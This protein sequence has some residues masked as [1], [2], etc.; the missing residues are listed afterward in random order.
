ME[1]NKIPIK[2]FIIILKLVI[3]IQLIYKYKNSTEIALFL[4]INRLLT[5]D[6]PLNE[7]HCTTPA[8]LF[9]SKNLPKTTKN[10]K[11]QKFFF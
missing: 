3:R 11:K 9:P 1:I 7:W 4:H 8:L 10:N 6:I 5:I 2:I